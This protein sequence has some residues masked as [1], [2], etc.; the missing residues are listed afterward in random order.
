M[1]KV[2]TR[3]ESNHR[4][5]TIIWLFY[6]QI[7][8]SFRMKQVQPKKNLKDVFRLNSTNNYYYCYCKSFIFISKSLFLSLWELINLIKFNKALRNVKSNN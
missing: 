6:Q 5:Q 1:S 3:I 7:Q 4:E 2:E 8:I